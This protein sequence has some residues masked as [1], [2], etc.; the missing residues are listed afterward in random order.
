MKHPRE[1]SPSPYGHCP[2]QWVCV[3][4]HNPYQPPRGQHTNMHHWPMKYT[5][6][7]TIVSGHPSAMSQPHSF[8][9]YKCLASNSE[10]PRIW[11]RSKLQQQTC[12][13]KVE[14][15]S[16]AITKKLETHNNHQTFCKNKTLT[17]KCITISFLGLL[18]SMYGII[19]KEAF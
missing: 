17:F 14:R 4:T 6:T 11:T 16:F 19:I 8:P 7:K 1:L 3:Y 12:R 10:H 9:Q 18:P 2:L 5:I 13:L 15:L